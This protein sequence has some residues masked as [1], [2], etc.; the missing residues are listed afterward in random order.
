MNEYE[1]KYNIINEIFKID[2]MI[3]DK[4][5]L[6]PKPI[7]INSLKKESIKELNVILDDYKYFLEKPYPKD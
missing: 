6:T 1:I 2:K 5:N 7:N 4:N 3:N